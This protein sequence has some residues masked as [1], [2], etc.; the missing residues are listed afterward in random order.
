M[1]AL[2]KAESNLFEGPSITIERA[3]EHIKEIH[4]FRQ[5]FAESVTW[6]QRVDLDKFT[7]ENLIYFC[8]DARIPN[9]IRGVASD[10]VN[11]LRHALDQTVCA[12]S[13]QLGAVRTKKAYFP[14]AKSK[15]DLSAQIKYRCKDVPTVLTP[16]L[17]AF[18]PYLGGDD[19][20][21]SL[22]RIAGPNKHQVPLAV[23]VQVPFM[24]C[25][26]GSMSGDVKFG[27][28]KW[29]RQKQEVCV[30]KVGIGGQLNQQ[31]DLGHY[32]SIGEVDVV[33]RQ[34]LTAVLDAYL[35]KVESIV[36]GIEAETIRLK[37]L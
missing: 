12:A 25:T 10:A 14:F 13:L 18:E 20:L 24:L 31:I 8:L 21:W 4:A 33:A 35:G 32:I 5:I 7:G 28:G 22:S 3:K 15:Y 17:A 2:A 6:R 9:R 34:P 37:S 23:E 30:A 11:N 26:K 19:L 16:F 29:D 1:N 27:L 36:L